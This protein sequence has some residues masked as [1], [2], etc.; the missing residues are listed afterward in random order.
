MVCSSDPRDEASRGVDDGEVVTEAAAALGHHLGQGA[1]V[2]HVLT[3]L[4]KCLF[5]SLGRATRARRRTER[6]T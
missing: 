1:R 2:A 3:F 5:G 6:H 4:S